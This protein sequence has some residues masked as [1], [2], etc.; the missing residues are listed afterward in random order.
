MSLL[1]SILIVIPI[2]WLPFTPMVLII[3]TQQHLYYMRWLDI[4]SCQLKVLP[5]DLVLSVQLWFWKKEIYPFEI[6]VE[7]QKAQ[8]NKKR[9][10]KSSRSIKVWKRLSLQLLKSFTIKQLRMR[11]DTDDYILSSYLFPLIQCFLV[12]RGDQISFVST[13]T[14]RGLAAA[15][16]K[17]PDLLEKYLEKRPAPVEA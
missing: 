16:E 1:I 14:N 6:L 3:D 7:E 17:V 2:L 8:K 10:R 5:D 11:L 4:G 9:K 15:F 13:K 12:S